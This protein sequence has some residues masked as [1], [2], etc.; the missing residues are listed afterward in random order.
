MALRLFALKPRI[1]RTIR[2]MLQHQ[3]TEGS[4]VDALSIDSVRY[5]SMR[6]IALSISQRIVLLPGGRYI[7]LERA[8]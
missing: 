1:F 3:K 4:K 6:T 5:E 8:A 7:G 2:R